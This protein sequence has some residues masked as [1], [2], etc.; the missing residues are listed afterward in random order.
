MEGGEEGRT[1][2]EGG[3]KSKT[4]EEGG[5]EIGGALR[6][7]GRDR[8]NRS[9]GRYDRRTGGREGRG[10]WTKGTEEPGGPVEGRLKGR[11]DGIDGW[12]DGMYGRGEWMGKWRGLEDE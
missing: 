5:W 10:G 6:V 11:T 9:V 7:H 8:G 4:G 2:F 12:R 1:S 3:Q